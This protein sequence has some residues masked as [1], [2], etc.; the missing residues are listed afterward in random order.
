MTDEQKR[1]V[2]EIINIFRA[3]ERF[4][5][6]M[7]SEHFQAQDNKMSERLRLFQKNHNQLIDETISYLMDE[8]P[9]VYAADITGNGKQ[10]EAS[11]ILRRIAKAMSMDEPN[12]ELASDLAERIDQLG[13]IRRLSQKANI[14]LRLV[15]LTP[16]WYKQDCGVFLGY[17]GSAKELAALIPDSPHS[18]RIITYKNPDGRYVN[19]EVNAELSRSAFICYAGLPKKVIQAKHV[20]KFIW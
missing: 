20:I 15:T 13:L 8:E 3:N 10:E 5:M 1:I 9:V 11:M 14:R 19:A 18:Y 7:L 4:F 17:Y 2:D 12:M 16:E 6:V